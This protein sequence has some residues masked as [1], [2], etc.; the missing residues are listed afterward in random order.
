MFARENAVYIAIEQWEPLDISS[1]GRVC[2]MENKSL[3]TILR[4]SFW[5]LERKASVKL[6]L[7][8]GILMPHLVWTIMY[9]QGNHLLT[10]AVQLMNSNSSEI[11]I[12]LKVWVKLESFKTGITFR[13]GPSITIV[14]SSGSARWWW[15]LLILIVLNF[16]SQSSLVRVE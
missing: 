4:R 7:W 12:Q 16:T 1:V 5:N 2:R 11:R 15:V 13:E 14:V 8:Y 6:K 3:P 9:S 10:S